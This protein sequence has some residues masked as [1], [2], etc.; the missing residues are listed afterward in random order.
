MKSIQ[1]MVLLVEPD[2]VACLRVLQTAGALHNRGIVSNLIVLDSVDDPDKCRKFGVAIFPAVFIN[3][4]LA[5]YGE[6]SLDDAIQFVKHI[7]N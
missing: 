5:F 1:E 2:C 6:F 4:H 7:K 3:G